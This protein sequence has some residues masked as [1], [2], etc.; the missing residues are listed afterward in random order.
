MGFILI[1]FFKT[2]DHPQPR[3]PPVLHPQDHSVHNATKHSPSVPN[4]SAMPVAHSLESGYESHPGSASLV[5][6]QVSP[7]G[8]VSSHLENTENHDE[9]ANIEHRDATKLITE[10]KNKLLKYGG[11]NKL[12]VWTKD[13]QYRIESLLHEQ[14]QKYNLDNTKKSSSVDN[15]QI[16]DVS[17]RDRKQS[18]ENF[19]VQR[20]TKIKEKFSDDLEDGECSGDDGAEEESPKLIPNTQPT[21]EQLETEPTPTVQSKDSP[22]LADISESSRQR[23]SRSPSPSFRYPH[24]HSPR[25]RDRLAFENRHDRFSPPPS[26][27][28]HRRERPLSPNRPPVEF[29][30]R[31]Y[32]GF[33][34]RPP[35]P[36]FGLHRRHSPSYDAY[37]R[38]PRSP[39]FDHRHHH[40]QHH[41]FSPPRRRPPSPGFPRHRDIRPVPHD[42][43]QRRSPSPG[44]RHHRRSPS[45]GRKYAG[46]LIR[47]EF[48][49]SP[50]RERVFY[51][52]RDIDRHHG[53]F[54]PRHPDYE[55]HRRKSPDP[56]NQRRS[57]EPVKLRE[58]R[59]LPPEF[60]ERWAHH[61]P[62]SPHHAR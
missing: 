10:A 16:D 5:P 32:R 1:S 59:E 61:G 38:I 60:R 51:S 18:N 41:R 2:K 53:G 26:D 46:P 54:S 58:H 6:D 47:R 57:P 17:P 21:S 23:F 34:A 7:F 44:F 39:G 29:D 28:F 4:L 52:P 3:V 12:K 55:R 35:S 42:F 20:K 14:N 48:D 9:S 8:L 25:M 15:R 27:F 13:L 56:R 50:H 30:N 62:P 40:H 36:S 11:D 22:S 49:F 43:V 19:E 24:E 31:N 45:P 33:G 37:H